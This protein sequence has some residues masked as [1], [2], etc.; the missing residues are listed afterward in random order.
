[1]VPDQLCWNQRKSHTTLP[2]GLIE[3]TGAIQRGQERRKFTERTPAHRPSGPPGGASHK[4]CAG[5]AELRS[6]VAVG[7]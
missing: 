5:K 3:D 7:T 6:P 2:I 1:M 4:D